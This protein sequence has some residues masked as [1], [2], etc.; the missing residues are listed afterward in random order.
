MWL[1]VA[2]SKQYANT[3]LLRNYCR[4]RLW[5]FQKV[6]VYVLLLRRAFAE[7]DFNESLLFL[8]LCER[9]NRCL[10]VPAIEFV[11]WMV[12]LAS[13]SISKLQYSRENFSRYLKT[14]WY[15]VF[16]LNSP[17]LISQY[18]FQYEICDITIIFPIIFIQL[19]HKS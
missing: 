10:F 7:E 16:S 9:H 14:F 3:A 15:F 6:H 12:F 5:P 4:R 18:R 17:H 19:L 1:C 13:V 8:S 11:F 2:T